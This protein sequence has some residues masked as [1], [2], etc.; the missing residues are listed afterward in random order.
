MK[1]VLLHTNGENCQLFKLKKP[2]TFQI[3]TKESLE[4]YGFNPEHSSHY[5]VLQFDN[6]PVEYPQHPNIKQKINTYRATIRPLSDF[7]G[8]K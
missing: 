3:W 4:K 1:Y 8:I 6:K 5:I 2:G 7:V